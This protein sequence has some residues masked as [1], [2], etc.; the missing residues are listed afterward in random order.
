MASGDPGPEWILSSGPP[1]AASANPKDEQLIAAARRVWPYVHAHAEKDFGARR[2]DPENVSLA[3]EVWEG[4]LQSVA[5]TFQRLRVSSAEI[6]SMDSYLIGAFRHRFS[7]ERRRQRRR[8]QTIHLVATAE[9]LDVIAAGRGMRV[10]AEAECRI[11]AKELISLMDAWLRKVWT[12]RQYGYSWREIAEYLSAGEQP[13]K[14]K[15]R[16]KLSTLRLKA[17]GRAT[18]T[19]GAT[20]QRFLL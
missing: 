3:V 15:F 11:L 5:K 12:A 9:E 4:V 8:E 6:A 1:T 18:R 2:H 19:R 13:V 16:Y 20:G 10:S 17:V 7:R 14:M